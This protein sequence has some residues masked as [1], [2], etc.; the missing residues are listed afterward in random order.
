MENLNPNELMMLD[1]KK[2]DLEGLQNTWAC[3]FTLAP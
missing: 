2:H 3:M 1:M